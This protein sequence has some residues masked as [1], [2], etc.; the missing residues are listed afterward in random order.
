MAN[1]AKMI[2]ETTFTIRGDQAHPVPPCRRWQTTNQMLSQSTG[3]DELNRKNVDHC[4]GATNAK[5][6]LTAAYVTPAHTT[7]E[8]APPR[9]FS[10]SLARANGTRSSAG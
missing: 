4:F 3:R 10:F 6:R 8:A 9:R 1:P 7:N 5:G 2:T